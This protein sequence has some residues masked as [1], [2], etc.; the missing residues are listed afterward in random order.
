MLLLVL[1]VPRP[2]GKAKLGTVATLIAMGTAWDAS[3]YLKRN[4]SK[5]HGDARGVID[6]RLSNRQSSQRPYHCRSR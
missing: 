3:N 2:F 6:A 4:K 5:L 1:P